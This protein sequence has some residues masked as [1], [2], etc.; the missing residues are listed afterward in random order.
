MFCSS[1][2]PENMEPIATEKQVKT[3]EEKFSKMILRNE[4]ELEK[5]TNEMTQFQKKI[6]FAGIQIEK[7]ATLIE[8]TQQTMT[9]HQNQLQE[10]LS[11][12]GAN[13]QH[14]IDDAQNEVV[15][16]EE[17]VQKLES[18]SMFMSP[19]QFLFILCSVAT[20]S[21]TVMHSWNQVLYRQ[22]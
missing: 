21:I 13:V 8:S 17:R 7:T 18:N 19:C 6:D 5:V 15:D 22:N 16:L 10:K 3:I 14:F 11:V 4:T 9:D 20:W 1:G 2:V 12:V